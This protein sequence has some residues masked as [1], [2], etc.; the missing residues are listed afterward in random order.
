VSETLIKSKRAGGVAQEVG[1]L[2]GKSPVLAEKKEEGREGER[3]REEGRRER[4][5][6]ERETGREGD[7][8]RARGNLAGEK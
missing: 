8:E 4:N 2:P 3:R 1:H 7:R 6:G 5:R